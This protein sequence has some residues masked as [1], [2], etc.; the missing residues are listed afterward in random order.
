VADQKSP[1]RGAC[2]ISG[3]DRRGGRSEDANRM[4]FCGWRGLSFFAGLL[5]NI[6]LGRPRTARRSA[7]RVLCVLCIP[8]LLFPF[9]LHCSPFLFLFL[10]LHL[11]FFPRVD[12]LHDI[13]ICRVEHPRYTEKWTQRFA[14]CERDVNYHWTTF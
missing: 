8:C 5:G 4:R 3:N 12:P 6:F 2:G 14:T 11:Y 13:C 10:S 1:V 7:L 9:L